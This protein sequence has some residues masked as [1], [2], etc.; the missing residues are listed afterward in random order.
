LR[1]TIL[2][3]N[4]ENEAVTFPIGRSVEP[5]RTR[6]NPRGGSAR[7]PIALAGGRPQ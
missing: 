6:F 2:V 1:L 3:C 5:A 7:A 4:L